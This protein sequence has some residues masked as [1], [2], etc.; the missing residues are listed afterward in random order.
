[1]AQVQVKTEVLPPARRHKRS[2]HYI[3]LLIATQIFRFTLRLKM[4][5]HPFPSF[6]NPNVTR[7]KG[8][9]PSRDAGRNIRIHAYR[10]TSCPAYEAL[11][12]LVN[13]HGSGFII[14]MLGQDEEWCTRVAEEARMLVIDADYRKAP[15]YPFP[16]GAEDAEDVVRHVLNHV[17]HT[18]LSIS[19]MSA[20]GNIAFGAAAFFGPERVRSIVSFYP[21]TDA[22]TDV[23][24]VTQDPFIPPSVMRHMMAC[25]I[26][27]GTPLDDPRVS[28]GLSRLEDL[29]K[30]I[31]V[32]AGAN[33]PLHVGASAFMARLQREGHPDA[34][35]VSVAGA[36]HGFD[37]RHGGVGPGVTPAGREIRDEAVA[38]LKKNSKGPRVA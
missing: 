8:I 15:E 28:P 6:N 26:L 2:F 38:F 16:H 32:A 4:W 11:P 1:M 3:R 24:T 12:V 34:V 17:P 30:H 29:P 21:S 27:P 5:I 31:W 25:Y 36:A 37:R 18:T 19:G 9:V 7:E 35:F 10:P 33:D 22:A 13:F 14:P 20:G 23:A